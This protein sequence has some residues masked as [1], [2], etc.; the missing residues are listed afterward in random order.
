MARQM[1]C[2]KRRNDIVRSRKAGSMKVAGLV[3]AALVGVGA[4]PSASAKT[5]KLHAMLDST[6]AFSN[7]RWPGRGFNDQVNSN[8]GASAG[9]GFWSADGLDR[10]GYPESLSFSDL[11]RHERVSAA[12]G[13]AVGPIVDV[14]A[15]KLRLAGVR[16]F[17][18]WLMLLVG[19]G[20]VACQLRR[21][22]RALQHP[23]GRLPN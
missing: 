18:A 9:A 23:L 16:Q 13:S 22:Q 7:L 21:K 5:I 11:V 4:M 15:G 6:P 19:A 20:L 17:D 10:V 12:T 14:D 3:L 1:L 2:L 8:L